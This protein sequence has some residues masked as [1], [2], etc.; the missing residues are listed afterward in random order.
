MQNQIISLS[1][2]QDAL[3][4]LGEDDIVKAELNVAEE[5]DENQRWEKIATLADANE[6]LQHSLSLWRAIKIYKAVSTQS[7]TN[8]DN[9]H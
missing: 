6:K 4:P 3:P 9:V 1:N 8:C 2:R 5:L 7:R